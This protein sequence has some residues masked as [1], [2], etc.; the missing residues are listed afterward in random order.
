MAAAEAA[1]IRWGCV[2]IEVTSARRRLEA[3]PFYLGL[4]YEDRCRR[5]A[6]YRREL[7][8]PD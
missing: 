2:T 4:G 5:S 6:L 3:H 1:A 7:T 8:E